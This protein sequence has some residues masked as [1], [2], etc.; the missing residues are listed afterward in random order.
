MYHEEIKK[1][2]LLELPTFNAL[3]AMNAIRGKRL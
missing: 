3:D 2:F 1:I